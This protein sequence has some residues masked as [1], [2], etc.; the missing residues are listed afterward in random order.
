MI[1]FSLDFIG[2]SAGF[3]RVGGLRVLVV[4]DKEVLDDTES[5]G[6][7]EATLHSP[8]YQSKLVEARILR[9]WD[10]IAEVWIR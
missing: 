4:S 9:E 5:E 10:V 1:E 2:S 6:G 3:A 8:S 7:D